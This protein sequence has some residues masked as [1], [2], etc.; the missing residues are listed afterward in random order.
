MAGAVQAVLVDSAV[1][2]GFVIAAV[3]NFTGSSWVVV[4]ALAGHGLVR[5]Y[6]RTGW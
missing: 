6:G 2:T 5:R 4:G 1:M 3:V